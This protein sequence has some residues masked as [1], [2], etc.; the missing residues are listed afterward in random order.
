MAERKKSTGSRGGS[1]KGSTSS[2]K[3]S[4]SGS[5]GSGRSGS[6]ASSQ[7]TPTASQR[8]PP[9]EHSPSGG[10]NDGEGNMPKAQ[11]AQTGGKEMGRPPSDEPD[12]YVFVPK[13]KV[14][15]L[16]I[17]VE[18]LDAHLALRAQVAGLLNLV[19][20]VHVSVEQVK[21][22]L[23][24]VE[25]ECELKVRLENTYNILDR[26]LTTLDENP[27]V[28]EKLLNTADTAVQETGQ[29]G[30]DA[31]KPGG[32]VSE[33]GSGVGDSL[34]NVTSSLGDSLSSVTQ[35]ANPK[36]LMSGN[37]S[38]KSSSSG[39]SN[40]SNPAR[41]VATAGAAGLAGLAGAVLFGGGRKSRFRRNGGLGKVIDKVRP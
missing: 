3:K 4:S 8:K 27:K 1:K 5:K 24:D 31:T 7:R 25:A 10:D 13:V 11:E 15:E 20:G 2:S 6:R 37:G 22:D 26:T 30:K 12:V 28:V 40:G 33:L 9:S 14:G 21:I 18:H 34:G 32:A 39:S 19:A 23:K 16:N 41:K 36:Q 35:K 29:I 38:G 17:D